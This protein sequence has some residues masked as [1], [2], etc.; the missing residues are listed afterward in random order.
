MSIIE[1]I[2]R[3]FAPHVC[4]GCEAE[5][6]AL[7]C[8]MCA[9]GLSVSL[10][11]CYRCGTATQDYLACSDCRM[12]APLVRVVAHTNYQGLAKRLVRATKYSRASAGA[13]E[14]GALLADYAHL[15]PA[16]VVLVHAPTA[17]SRAR[18]R[19]YDHTA[20]I[21]REVARLTGFS[22]RVVLARHGQTRQAGATRSERQ[23]Q[24]RGAFRVI[25]AEWV[26]GRH[27]VLIDDVLTTGVTLES[28]ARSLYRA[29]A[30]QV[31][32]LVFARA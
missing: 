32:A 10:S 8:P 30:Q 28:A 19:G 5:E 6:D 4:L 3:L 9:R 31:D 20:I 21:A 27:I 1:N 29:G 23:L 7:L 25:N 13:R 14:M 18:S 15:F 16:D 12:R 26:R 11:Q 24:L 22:R 17:T 2:A